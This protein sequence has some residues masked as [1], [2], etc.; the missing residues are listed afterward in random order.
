M[1]NLFR[2]TGPTA[3]SLFCGVGG[4]SMGFVNAGYN[5]L[6]ANDIDKKAIESYRINFPS[7][8]AEH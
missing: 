7:T 4:C 6:Y 1:E 8:K 2:N 5:V 3:I